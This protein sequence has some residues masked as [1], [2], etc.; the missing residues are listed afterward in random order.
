MDYSLIIKLTNNCNLNCSYC[1]HRR[2][3]SRNLSLSL[4]HDQIEMMIKKILEHNENHAE[5][6]WHGGEPLLAG[7]DTFRFIVDKQ[8][9]HNRKGLK[10]RNSVQTNGTLLND[11]YISFFREN[12]F[13]IGISIDGPFDMHTSERGTSHSEYATILN[14]LDSLSEIDTRHG[15]LCVVGKQHVGQAQR[16]FDLMVEHNIKGIGFLP[17]MVHT[18][19]IIDTDV[20]ISPEEFGQFLIDLFEIWINGGVKG[21]EIRNFDDCLRFFTGHET[22]TCI[23]CNRCDGYLTIMPDGGI[24]LC[25]N[26]SSSEE[27]RVGTIDE[28]FD[29][30]ENA[31]AMLWL[32]DSIQHLPKGCEA[33]KYFKSCHGGCKYRRWLVDKSMQKKQYYC[34]S[35]RMLYNHVGK[36]F[37][38]EAT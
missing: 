11:E 33:C 28:G 23:S 5:F 32:K 19:G 12:R 1:Y 26:F 16:V 21:I 6:I 31:P 3:L 17:C 34:K 4:S 15:T 35:H 36:Y 13:S 18:D 7:I 22:R 8:T 9:E 29:H 38:Q 20:T 10:I 25:D 37:P 27:H 30:I 2:D 24:Y 14:A